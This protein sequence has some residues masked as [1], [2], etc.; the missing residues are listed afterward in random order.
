MANFCETHSRKNTRKTSSVKMIFW[1]FGISHVKKPSWEKTVTIWPK[2]IIGKGVG[3]GSTELLPM[4][5]RASQIVKMYFFPTIIPMFVIPSVSV[6]QWSRVFKYWPETVLYATL[7]Q[8]NRKNC[9]PSM[10][11][12]TWH[13]SSQNNKMGYRSLEFRP[14]LLG[15]HG[16]SVLLET[17][18][19][20]CGRKTWFV[21]NSPNQSNE[22]FTK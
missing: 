3:L 4:G 1:W 20:T 10:S 6:G 16:S 17:S 19:T 21:W 12:R 9:L 2:R 22:S 8:T 18:E 15:C 11:K 7:D 5:E 14:D 13:V